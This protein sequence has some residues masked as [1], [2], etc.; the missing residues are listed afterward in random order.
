MDLTN[1]GSYRI[2]VYPY[3][4]TGSPTVYANTGAGVTFIKIPDN[5]F[6]Q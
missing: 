6:G 2:V 5:K 1:D 4:N 3:S